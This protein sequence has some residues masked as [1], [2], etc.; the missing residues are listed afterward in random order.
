MAMVGRGCLGSAQYCALSHLLP[1]ESGRV[2]VYLALS[3]SDKLP[4][5]EI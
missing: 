3:M 4:G 2:L 5:Q 1:S